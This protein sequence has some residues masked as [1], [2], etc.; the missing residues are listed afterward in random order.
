MLNR[1]SALAGRKCP[2]TSSG[3]AR[4]YFTYLYLM[5]ALFVCSAN[6]D[7]SRTAEDH[8]SGRYPDWRFDSAGTNQKI[9]WQLGTNYLRKEQ[10]DWADRVFV[11]ENKHRKAIHELFG[12]TYQDKITVLHIPDVYEYGDPELIQVLS[13][14]IDFNS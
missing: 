7:R 14:K 9:C 11:M 4:Q 12:K 3:Q 8:F 13:S 5:N 1:K 10:L 2:S 6:K